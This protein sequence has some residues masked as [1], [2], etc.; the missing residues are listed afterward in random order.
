MLLMSII[1]NYYSHRPELAFLCSSVLFRP[2]SPSFIWPRSY[3]PRS[4]GVCN[5]RGTRLVIS[6]HAFN[7]NYFIVPVGRYYD[8]PQ[9]SS[10]ECLDSNNFS[11]SRRTIVAGDGFQ[12]GCAL[13][14][15]NCHLCFYRSR[16][17]ERHLLPTIM[18]LN[19]SSVILCLPIDYY[20]YYYSRIEQQTLTKRLGT[21]C[22]PSPHCICLRKKLV[23]YSIELNSAFVCV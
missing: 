8:A 15:G 4:T 3:R 18:L 14:N 23:S 13:P 2:R 17:R 11:N 7:S 19:Y 5:V 9:C 12:N 21:E 20:Y 10:S 1:I 22:L 6:V 16:R